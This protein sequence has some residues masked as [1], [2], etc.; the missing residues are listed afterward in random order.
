MIIIKFDFFPIKQKSD[1]IKLNFFPPIH[2]FTF[3]RHSR[4]IKELIYENHE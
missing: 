4:L 3:R 2:I 1:K